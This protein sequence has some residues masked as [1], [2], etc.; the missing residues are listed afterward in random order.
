MEITFLIISA[1]LLSLAVASTLRQ[2][3]PERIAVRINTNR[4]RPK[5]ENHL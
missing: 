5:R 2:R 4:R 1:L 3:N